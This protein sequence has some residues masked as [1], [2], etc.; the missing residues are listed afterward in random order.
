M[1][2][3]SLNH[4]TLDSLTLFCEAAD[5]EDDNI[6]V[7]VRLKE[8][9]CFGFTVFTLRNLQRQMEGRL[10]FVTPGLLVVSR[11]TDEAL[12]DAVLCAASLGIEHFGILQRVGGE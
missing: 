12:L 3:I 10:S 11:L 2:T 6:D 4:D 1:R 9:R 5:I 8:G 7:S